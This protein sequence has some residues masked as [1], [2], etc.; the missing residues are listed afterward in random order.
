LAGASLYAL[1][2]DY[3]PADFSAAGRIFQPPPTGH[4]PGKD[5]GPG[6][7]LH[8]AGEDCGICHRPDGKAANYVF[9]LAGTLYQDR[10]AR[11]VSSGGEVVLQDI[12]GN[13]IS[14]TPNEVGNFWT[15]TPL[16][17][18]PYAVAS[19]G[20]ITEPLY[21]DTTVADPADS[22]TW[23]YKAWVVNGDQVVPMV[24]IA[25]VGGSTDPT[26][27]MSCNMHHG[28]MGSRGG[29]W[30]SRQSTLASYPE[31]GLSFQRHILPIFRSKCIPCHI[32]GATA[33]RLATKTDLDDPSTSLDYSNGQDFTSYAGSDVGGALK[34]GV[35]DFALAYVAAPDESPLLT[36]TLPGSAGVVSHAGGWYWTN[37]DADYKAIRQWISE[38]ALDN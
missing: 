1:A 35:V 25:P 24:T 27:R 2:V 21:T 31:A 30:G 17:S 7:G 12:G 8:N 23:Q 5:N 6:A 15:Y 16:A 13:T 3:G 36:T 18:N 9:T 11:R 10:M 20:G 28:S 4:A 37:A 34:K 26:S 22:R 29:L 14:M 32:P 33:T 19:H 38:G